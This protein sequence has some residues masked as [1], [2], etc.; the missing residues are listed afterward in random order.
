MQL[1]TAP[2]SNVTVPV[3]SSDVTEGTTDVSSLVFTS[4]NWNIAQTITTTGQQDYTNDGNQSFNIVLGASNSTDSVYDGLAAVD[5]TLTNSE[6][7]NQAPVITLPAAQSLEENTTLTV[8]TSNGNAITVAD[9]DADADGS[10]ASLE[11]SLSVSQGTVSFSQNTGLNFLSGNGLDNS[12]IVVTGT[13]NDLNNAID[14][15]VYTPNANYNGSDTLAI[16]VNDQGA[17]GTGG[18]QTA[19]ELLALTINPVNAIPVFTSTAPVAA[20][21]DASYTYNV[22]TSDNDDEDTLSITATRLPDWLVL[23]DQGDGTAIL[24]G[25][26]TNTDVG[27]NAVELLVTDAAG[28]SSTQRFSITVDN[29]RPVITSADT[30]TVAENTTAITT[31]SST[32]DGPGTTFSI[33]N[34]IDDGA[35]FSLDPVTGSLN[36]LSAPDFENPRDSNGDNTYT[37]TVQVDDGNGQLN[38]TASQVIAIN[39]TDINETDVSDISD[40]DNS[41]D[42]VA[43][44]S[45]GGTRVGITANAIDP[46]ATSSAI[47]YT[48]I[49]DADGRFSIDSASGVITVSSVENAPGLDFENQQNQKIIIR[50]TSNDGSFSDSEKQIAIIDRNEPPRILNNNSQASSTIDVQENRALATTFV[51]NDVDQGSSITYAIVGGADQDAFFIEPDSGRLSFIDPP[52]FENKT[53]YEV[54]IRASDNGAPSLSDTQTLNIVISDVNEAP[55]VTST[56][57]QSSE[58]S[59]G[60]VGVLDILDPDTNDIVTLEV[61]GGNAQSSIIYNE[62]SGNLVQIRTLAGGTYTLDIVLTDSNNN[63]TDVTLTIEVLDDPDLGMAVSAV[64]DNSESTAAVDSTKLEPTGSSSFEQSET[65]SPTTSPL[66]EPMQEIAV[67]QSLQID[68]E[69]T[70]ARLYLQTTQDRTVN[71]LDIEFSD[72]NTSA[73]SLDDLDE[74]S[75]RARLIDLLSSLSNDEFTVD[76]VISDDDFQTTKSLITLNPYSSVTTSSELEQELKKAFDQETKRQQIIL[77]VSGGTAV[78]VTTGFLTW[79]LSTGVLLSAASTSSAL[80]RNFDPIPV[81][82]GRDD[83]K[84]EG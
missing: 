18:A 67:S 5:V 25:I 81:L 79:L 68:T 50:A 36:F 6:V 32:D 15:L 35:S 54:V 34:D 46:D 26:P 41:V 2:T 4:T 12:S 56:L 60:S 62:E 37:L 55:R 61:V 33:I 27:E 47:I 72:T 29:T 20:S 70:A 8:S 71:L 21:E 48:L 69:S 64:T 75:N 63:M 82:D 45:S 39:V 30:F 9:A 80:W 22:T 31:L 57:F 59:R 40:L 77:A 74:V 58:G 7:V 44:N 53:L 19:S 11:L 17:S 28:T 24:S 49:D 78:I 38:S 83:K 66:I 84:P 14:G 76:S 65:Q 73:Q 13:A 52:D 42:A 1:A 43:E 51:A 23:T 3:F 10:S 16:N